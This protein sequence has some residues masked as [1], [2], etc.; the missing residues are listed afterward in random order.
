MKHTLLV[1]VALIMVVA[2]A[3]PTITTAQTRNVTFLVNTAT[4]PDTVIAGYTIQI[5]GNTAPLTW[6]AA[7]GGGLT[8][9]GGD[10]WSTT[11]AFPVGSALEYKI[12]AGSNGWESNVTNTTGATGNRTYTVADQDTV[13]PLQFFNSRSGN[14]PQYFRPWTTVA[15]SFMNVYFR[16]NMLGAEQ[17]SLFG[18]NPDVDTVGVRGGG[19]ANGDLNW[20]PTFYLTKEPPA[21]EGEFGVPARTFWSARLRFP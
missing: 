6:D 7:T 19:P 17:G 1:A 15:D 18:Y 8:N 16:V 11:I 5:R 3:A 12:F 13:L 21:N 9:I 4:V 2:L 10:Y 14:P 20:S